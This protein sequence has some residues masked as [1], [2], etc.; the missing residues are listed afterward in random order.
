MEH[1]SPETKELIKPL[2]ATKKSEVVSVIVI[3][4]IKQK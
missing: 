1:L 3:L 4:Y 2:R